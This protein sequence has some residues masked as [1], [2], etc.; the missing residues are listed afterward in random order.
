MCA[1]SVAQS[2]LT[3][4][5]SK[6]C[7]SPGSSVHGISQARIMQWVAIFFSRGTSQPREPT[8]VFRS[9]CIVGRFITTEPQYCKIYLHPR[10][11]CRAPTFICPNPC[12]VGLALN[13][14]SFFCLTNS[15]LFLDTRWILVIWTQDR[16]MKSCLHMQGTCVKLVAEHLIVAQSGCLGGDLW[17]LGLQILILRLISPQRTSQ[18]PL[19][20]YRIGCQLVESWVGKTAL[21]LQPAP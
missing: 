15:K 7:I 3:L 19:S 5:I 10:N 18:S 21:S 4:C 13:C 14:F 2:C 20:G 12:I 1:C 8:C 6:D 17:R 11:I 16:G 9:S